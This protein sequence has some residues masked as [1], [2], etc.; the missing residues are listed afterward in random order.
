MLCGIAG[1]MMVPAILWLLPRE[2]KDGSATP[3]ATT[4]SSGDRRLGDMLGDPFFFMMLPALMAPAF[5]ETAMNL[6]QLTIADMKGW[7]HKWVTGGYA[8]FAIMTVVFSMFAG[9]L[10]DR[11][12]AARL[13]PFGI[14]PLAAG[15]LVVAFFD[16][17]IWAWVYLG[18]FGV[19]SGLMVTCVPLL[20]ADVYGTQHIG[21]IRGFAATITA[22][23]SAL[24]PSVLG[25]GLD[26]AVPLETMAMV[27]SVYVVVATVM[28]AYACRKESTKAK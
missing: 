11:V 17:Y 13:M 28:M 6:H 1:L 21:S 12:G 18:L 2:S 27:G 14:L 25:L 20:L 4:G 10:A 24:A 5:L 16:H 23:S 26:A 15:V 7:S 3:S 9:R 8:I 19:S 22:F